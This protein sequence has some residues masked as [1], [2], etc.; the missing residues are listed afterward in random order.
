M[1][2]TSVYWI[3]IFEIL[4]KITG[5][6]VGVGNAR[7]MKNVPGRPKTDKADARWIARL[8]MMGLII[9][10]FVVGPRFRELREYTRYYKKLTQESAR[11]VNRI[12]KLLQMNGFK[13]SSVLGDIV[14]K[15]GVRLLEKLC[16][17]GFVTQSDVADLINGRVK[18]NRQRLKAQ[19]MAK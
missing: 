5:M 10:S 12:E 19:L 8:C 11:Q 1:E 15:S 2:S 7:H 17:Q 6:D 14:G 3:P 9:K 13:L 4:E 16:S 18:K